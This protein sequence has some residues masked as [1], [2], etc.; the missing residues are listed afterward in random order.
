MFISGLAAN[1][2]LLAQ[3]AHRKSRTLRQ[4]HKSNHL[5]HRA[6]IFPRHIVWNCNPSP[7]FVCYLS[8]R[9]EPL[10][11]LNSTG[12]EGKYVLT[13]LEPAKPQPSRV[14][15]EKRNG[16]TVGI[17]DQPVSEQAIRDALDEFPCVRTWRQSTA[18]SSALSTGELSTPRRS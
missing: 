8:L 11:T 2:E 14:R 6:H 16:Y 15:F 13:R 12:E 3:L 4:H 1:A 5:V 10:W 9:F 17:S 18:S 7:R